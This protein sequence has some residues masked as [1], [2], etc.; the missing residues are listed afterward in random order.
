MERGGPAWG[1]VQVG[2]EAGKIHLAADDFPERGLSYEQAAAPLAVSGPRGVAAT[3]VGLQRIVL[4]DLVSSRP[5]SS[6]LISAQCLG[7]WQCP[8]QSL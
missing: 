1:W 8:L 3:F 4:L 6:A 2:K 7:S 5:P